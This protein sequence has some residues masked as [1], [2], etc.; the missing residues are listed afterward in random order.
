M[1]KQNVNYKDHVT[2]FKNEQTVSLTFFET[3]IPYTD[4]ALNKEHPRQIF[5]DH[6]GATLTATVDKQSGGIR[7]TTH[8]RTE[9]QKRGKKTIYAMTKNQAKY[10]KQLL[11]QI[12]EALSY[13]AKSLSEIKSIRQVLNDISD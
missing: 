6:G 7:F 10:L 11:N 9:K 8:E 4:A 2:R 12:T 5:E 3:Q 13:T 1:F